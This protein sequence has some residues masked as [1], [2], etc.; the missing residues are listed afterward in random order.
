M[1]FVA[2]SVGDVALE[3]VVFPLV[4]NVLLNQCAPRVCSTNLLVRKCHPLNFCASC[5]SVV[6]SSFVACVAK[7]VNLVAHAL[8][9][10]RRECKHQTTNL[11]FHLDL[12]MLKT[13]HYIN[14]VVVVMSISQ[15]SADAH[16]SSISYSRPKKS[17]SKSK[18]K[19]KGKREARS[20]APPSNAVWAPTDD[21]RLRKA[22]KHNSNKDWE[23]IAEAV[24]EMAAKEKV[25]LCSSC[26]E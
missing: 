2:A 19:K 21:T 14:A 17:R 8:S 24:N 22:M 12:P 13:Y 18:K 3:R 20:A 9:F 25:R 15:P 23:A 11:N 1:S 5:C 26:T 4:A 7:P 16:E 10:A 6:I